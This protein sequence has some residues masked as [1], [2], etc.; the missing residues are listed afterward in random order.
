MDRTLT[1]TGVGTAVA[2]PDRV[3][4][5]GELNGRCGT[6]AEAVEASADS[7]RALKKAIGD[8]GFDMDSLKTT[9][10]SVSA[11]YRQVERDGARVN[12]FDG[13]AYSHRL[14]IA[15]DAEDDN[16]G[17]LLEAMITSEGAPEF[18]VTYL[19]SDPSA[20]M[21]RARAAAVKDARHRA[22]ELAEAAGVKLG[23]I[24]SIAYVSSPCRP[25]AARRMMLSASMGDSITPEDAEY[26]DS[27]TVTWEI[28][29]R[30]R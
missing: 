8:A 21:A 15:V 14:T 29:E 30:S 4:I 18:H 27:V 6:Y 3:R 1:V 9:G 2:A 13:F 25:S 23:G 5:D 12:A 20:P 19:V 28:S 10:F 16:L 11:A 24:T 26:Q 17:R 7:V 22:K